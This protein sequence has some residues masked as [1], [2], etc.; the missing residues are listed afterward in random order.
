MPQWE[1]Q[2]HTGS[3]TEVCRIMNHWGVEHWELVSMCQFEAT[4]SMPHQ[5][6]C[7]FKRPYEA[8]KE[9]PDPR[10]EKANHGG[11]TNI[12]IDDNE[13]DDDTYDWEQ[14]ID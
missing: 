12:S 5:F 1:Y 2:N 11:S 13:D 9:L 3:W 8:P 4:L 10:L 7:V 6:Y 14:M